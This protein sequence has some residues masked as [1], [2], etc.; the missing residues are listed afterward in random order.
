MPTAGARKHGSCTPFGMSRARKSQLTFW[1][2]MESR[3]RTTMKFGKEELAYSFAKATETFYG[4]G[5]D[6]AKCSA[7]KGPMTSFTVMS[8]TTVA[9]SLFLRGLW[10]SGRG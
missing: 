5:A 9:S 3:V 10:A 6:C 2:T 4:S 7:D 1:F 8:I